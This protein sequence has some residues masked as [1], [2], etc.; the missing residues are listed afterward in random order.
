MGYHTEFSGALLFLSPLT[1]EEKTLL[2]TFL[3]A[4]CRQHPEWG[5]K[6]LT[7]ID[8]EL[9]HDEDGLQWNESE[10]SYDMV[11]K[12][13]PIITQMKQR[14]PLFGLQGALN[15]QGD[16]T[17]DKWIL[18]IRDGVAVGVNASEKVIDSVCPHCGKNIILSTRVLPSL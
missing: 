9:T 14:F 15:A 12:V 1:L 3:G 7:Y 2:Q 17:E 8:F 6:E 4:D 18:M 13:N 16:E 5:A 11:E 10:K